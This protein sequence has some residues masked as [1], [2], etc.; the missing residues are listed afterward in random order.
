M[1]VRS[2]TPS[3]PPAARGTSSPPGPRHG[4]SGEPRTDS[5][6]ATGGAALR[7]DI[8]GLRAVAVSLVVLSHCQVPHLAGGY[9]GV[10]VFFVISGFLITSLMLREW[11]REGRISLGRFYARRALRLLPAATLVVI[12]TLAGAWLFLGRLRFADYAEDAVAS[13]WYLVNFRLAEAGTDYF[14]AD[15][16]PSPFQHFWSLAVEE[17]FYLV[18]PVLLIAALR[19]FRRRVLLTV[20]LLVLAAAS[21]ALNLHLTGTS[22][23]W[24]YFGS[25]GRIWE[26]AAGALLA[27][28]AHRLDALP[29]PA[30]AALS[31]AGLAAIGYAAVAFDESTRF[32]GHHALIPVLGSAAV[33]AGGAA[34]ARY[35]A[36]AV[37]SLRPAVWIGGLSYAWYLWHWPLI[38]I[39]PAAVGGGAED[40]LLRLPAALGGIV[41]AWLT[42]RLVE[43]PVRFHRGLRAR[44]G[45]GLSLGLGLSAAAAAAAVAAAQ[46]PPGLDSGAPRQSTRDALARAFDPAA[47]LTELLEQPVERL[48]ANLEP[49]L[50]DTAYGRTAVYTDG[51]ALTTADEMQTHPCRYGDPAGDRTV[52]LFGDSHAAQWFPAL[53]AIARTHRWRLYSFT[54]NA[55]KISR[56]TIEL[57]GGPYATCDTWRAETLGRILELEPDLVITS[58]SN[59]AKLYG[60]GQDDLGTAWGKGQAETYRVLGRGGIRVLTLLDNPWP[61]S[62]AVDCAVAN[63][64]RLSSCARHRSEAD[65]RPEVTEAI[66]QAAAAERVPVLDP[67]DWVCAP[68]GNCPV[69]VGNTMVY[70]DY[71]HLADGFVA[72]LTPVLEDELLRLFGADLSGRPGA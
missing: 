17:Q 71:G 43:D 1:S 67:Y 50:H 27:L 33:L 42:L 60:E 34:G 23:S 2:R 36:R 5:A 48:P 10:D 40:G 24:A 18:W 57:N 63:P 54:K 59:S 38:L 55:C 16:P 7:P 52:V 56:I 45:R 35:G 13:A 39:V 26:L 30:A 70:R 37:L 25:P 4:A 41:L 53:E 8:Q 58:N 19:L 46:F 47:A 21:F 51:C 32:P 3:P 72:A 69:V 15:V 61:K 6:T 65:P 14:N 62:N 31:W 68:S 12:A 44:A 64:G 49:S 22:P 29:R 20:P 66:R 9:I 28:A 11:S